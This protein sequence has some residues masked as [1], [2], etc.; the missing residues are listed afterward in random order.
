MTKPAEQTP[1]ADVLDQKEL[2]ESACRAISA[3][4]RRLCLDPL[5]F[6]RA[7][8]DGQI[9]DLILD[10]RQAARA[11]REGASPPAAPP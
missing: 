1:V 4:A 7:C 8:A 11:R 9:A 5:Q 3:A 10:L 2:A 6:A